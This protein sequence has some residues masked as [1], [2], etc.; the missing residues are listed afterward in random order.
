VLLMEKLL[1]I[2]CGAYYINGGEVGEV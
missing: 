2:S 1:V